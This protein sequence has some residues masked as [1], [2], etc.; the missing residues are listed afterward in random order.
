MVCENGIS[1]IQVKAKNGKPSLLFDA[2]LK[3]L[4]GDKS[5]ALEQYA[6]VNTPEFLNWYKG[7]LDENGEPV[8]NKGFISEGVNKYY[9]Q[10]SNSNQKTKTQDLIDS[11]ILNLKRK[12]KV[13]ENQEGYDNLPEKAKLHTKELKTLADAISELEEHKAVVEYLVASQRHIKSARTR[14]D[15]LQKEINNP[16]SIK[17]KSQLLNELHQV[18]AYVSDY[19]LAIQMAYN[20]ESFNNIDPT[21]RKKYD[22]YAT[23]KDKDLKL[24]DVI[25]DISI[26][27]GYISQTYLV[28]AREIMADSLYD[29]ED[30]SAINEELKA[31]GKPIITKETFKRELAVSSKDIDPFSRWFGS[32]VS[33]NDPVLASFAKR[34]KSV[35]D[36]VR[37]NS[38]STEARIDQ[39]K[40]KYEAA[41]GI[42]S[43][44]VK[45]FNAPFY[46]EVDTINE[47]GNPVKRL[48]FVD[49]INYA[50]YEKALREKEIETEKRE[51]EL[52]K[53]LLISPDQELI[54]NQLRAVRK[55]LKDWKK[56]NFDE[57]KNEPRYSLWKNQKY[58]SLEA[59][60]AA[61]EYYSVLKDVF[62]S[63]KK[64]LP[65]TYR[66][67]PYLPSIRREKLDRLGEGDWKSVVREIKSSF[68]DPI[69]DTD[70]EYGLLTIDGQ[71]QKTVPIFYHNELTA[72][73]T[74]YDLY[75]S[76]TLYAKMADNYK[77]LSSIQAEVE[78]FTDIINSRNAAKTTTSGSMVQEGFAKRIGI[79]R[80][81]NKSEE[82]RF[83]QMFNDY[84]SAIYYGETK[85][86][87]NK[88]LLKWSNILTKY[89][90]Q[91]SLALNV[92][93]AINNLAY[94]QIQNFIESS[95]SKFY[96]PQDYKDG[97][98]LYFSN[99]AQILADVGK[100]SDKSKIS[101]VSELF[102]F[103]QGF[104]DYAIGDKSTTAK[105]VINNDPLMVLQNIG[106]HS[107][108]YG[109][110][111]A[112]L[113]GTK[114]KTKSGETINLY[115]AYEKE[116]NSLVFRKDLALSKEE[117]N[118]I[119]K[120]G[121]E[122][123]SY[124]FKKL[125]GNYS[126]LDSVA[127]SR[128]VMGRFALLFRK[129]IYTGIKR[130][131]WSQTVN[132]EAGIVEEGSYI[133]FFRAVANSA[134]A[135]WKLD[136]PLFLTEVKGLYSGE[137]RKAMIEMSAALIIMGT[138]GFLWE[139]DEE[140]ADG[141]SAFVKYQL[142]RLSSDL[143]FYVNPFDMWR[144]AKNPTSAIGTVNKML[145]FLGQ[146]TN[147]FEEY[148]RSQGTREKGDNKLFARFQDLIPVITQIEN[149]LTPEE[150]LSAFENL[151]V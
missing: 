18:Q 137:A 115:D 67:Y 118:K 8:F 66:N 17:T 68:A 112:Y 109:I 38:I 73:E 103:R 85:A 113:K 42:S 148:E 122:Q 54:S 46:E 45:L 23:E 145:K 32:L 70:T 124:L 114:L 146:L 65:K 91:N 37:R 141:A 82:P 129:H 21:E 110:G 83:R 48:A 3:D 12:V 136:S 13:Y 27:G 101:L 40:K 75:R 116:G 150:Q 84:L 16:N 71:E 87:E 74:S 10:T 57:T 63:S 20:Y 6:M 88:T 44:N 39:A 94:G 107:I 34:V 144:T 52:K 90:A 15:S 138:I 133:Q 125:Q 147:P 58:E 1:E 108:G 149:L 60:K 95:G 131:W 5:E 140:E 35:V 55:D 26:N 31:A 106:E 139:D 142:T 100:A 120:K 104:R 128:Y 29:A 49:K 53:L 99:S 121:Q 9:Y 96:S 86:Q 59:N 134:K 30:F 64:G 143:F 33:V 123:I 47:L 135:A 119:Q 92:Y 126:Q 56:T 50:G 76:M 61:F 102:E 25:S 105:N 72:E 69:R 127:A 97:M 22:D 36:I 77:Q 117:L 79:Q 81:I 151:G 51:E 98:A 132:Y 4:N 130:R 24:E 19:T 62:E 28:L 93:S 14:F 80:F 41:S 89:V 2:I 11:A 111:L 7:E 43:N 78:V